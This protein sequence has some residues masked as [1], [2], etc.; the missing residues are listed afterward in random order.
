MQKILKGKQ[1]LV[2]N[3]KKTYPSKSRTSRELEQIK[4]IENFLQT[5]GVSVMLQSGAEGIVINFKLYEKILKKL[6]GFTVNHK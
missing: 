2:S 1:N 5:F 3:I 4:E 6:K